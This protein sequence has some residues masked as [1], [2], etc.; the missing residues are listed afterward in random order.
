MNSNIGA[1]GAERLAG[2]SVARGITVRHGPPA[3]LAEAVHVP[4]LNLSASV[5]HSLKAKLM[6]F[7]AGTTT[8]V[9]VNA[10]LAARVNQAGVTTILKPS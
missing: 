3:D 10:E 7:L 4:T 9:Q 1:K 5:P 2:A 6:R 8:R